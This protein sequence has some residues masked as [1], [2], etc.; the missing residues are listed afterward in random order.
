MITSA[1]GLLSCEVTYSQASVCWC[2]YLSSKVC[3]ILR[4]PH[5]AKSGLSSEGEYNH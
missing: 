5:H 2:R 4:A 3:I 1:D